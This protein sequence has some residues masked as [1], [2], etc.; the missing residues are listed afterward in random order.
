[1]PSQYLVTH[2]NDMVTMSNNTLTQSDK[3]CPAV[4]R[5]EQDQLDWMCW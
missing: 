4:H 3:N 2:G 1:M 5:C